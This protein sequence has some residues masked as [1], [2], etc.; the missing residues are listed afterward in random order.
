MCRRFLF[1]CNFLFHIIS[2]FPPH[3]VLFLY[4]SPHFP[5]AHP[6][7]ASLLGRQRVVIPPSSVTGICSPSSSS[8]FFRR[9]FLTYFLPPLAPFS[10]SRSLPVFLHFAPSLRPPAASLITPS[11]RHLFQPSWYLFS[12]HSHLTFAVFF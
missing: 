12:C 5:S 10:L 6:S 11:S 9:D 7:T 3:N 2:S 1:C 4:P 8:F